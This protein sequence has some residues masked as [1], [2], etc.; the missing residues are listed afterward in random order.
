MEDE[1]REMIEKLERL[2][3]RHRQAYQEL[4]RNL[5]L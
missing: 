1:E 3:S 4:Q 2:Q 5:A